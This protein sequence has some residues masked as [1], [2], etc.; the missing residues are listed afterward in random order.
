MVIV[1]PLMIML[2]VLRTFWSFHDRCGGGGGG[3][4]VGAQRGWRSGAFRDEPEPQPAW[5]RL[6]C[7]AVSSTNTCGPVNTVQTYRHRG[8]GG[9]T[10]TETRRTRGLCTASHLRSVR[11][12]QWG[13]SGFGEKADPEVY[14]Y[15][16]CHNT[17]L[18]GEGGGFRPGTISASPN[19]GA[20]GTVAGNFGTPKF[21]GNNR[22][23][24]SKA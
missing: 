9:H 16:W 12:G 14:Q 2:W 15:L 23:Q 10:A 4:L 5:S 17:N 24:I 18:R 7:R 20:L 11:S 13:G 6:L 21:L 22:C 8:T 1:L 19:F 3:R